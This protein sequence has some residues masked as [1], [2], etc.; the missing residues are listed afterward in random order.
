MPITHNHIWGKIVNFENLYSAF[1]A[2]SRSKR[3]R[4][5]VLRYQQC[6][7]E[8]LIQ[9]LNQL[10]WKQWQP[11]RYREFYVYEPKKRTIHAPPF[12]DRVIHH[13]LVRVI[14]PLF[15]RKF[16]PDS[17]ACRT[18]KGTH[19]AQL[20]VKSF[21]VAADKKWGDYYVLKADIKGYFPSID[22]HV[23][24]DLIKR[25]ISDKEV[26]WLVSQIINC[27][28]DKRG[29]PI[30]ALTSQLFANVYLD[31]L[32]HYV[33]DDLGVKMYAR[34]MDDFIII[35]PDHDYLKGLLADIGIFIAERLHLTFNPKTTIFKSGNSTCHPIDFCGYRMWPDHTKPRKRIVKAARKRF[36]KFT[37]LYRQRLMAP[38]QIRA[39]LMSFLG[40]MK[41][42]HGKR[43]VES[44]LHQLVLTRPEPPFLTAQGE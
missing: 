4:G 21:A 2:A 13:A 33:K 19:A 1:R 40:Y 7:E 16:I 14:E 39:S 35:H 34:Y 5:S 15:E 29:L 30:G 10:A 27:D 28:G 44:I 24:F 8:N 18:G 17:Y 43:S 36:K 6:L 9:A 32:D 11:S 3:F 22:R 37:E 31:A 12:K 42:C 20:R 23:L 38:E 25:T 26:L 41:H